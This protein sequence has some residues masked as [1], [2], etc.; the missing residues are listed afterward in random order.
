ME[1]VEIIYYLFGIAASAVAIWRFVLWL[2]REKL[3][4]DV[5]LVTRDISEKQFSRGVN[6]LRVKIM[7]EY[8]PDLILVISSG[9]ATVGG[10]LSAHLNVPAAM[11]VRSNPRLQ[12]TEPQKSKI[13][14]FP[15]DEIIKG[16]NILL[17]DDEVHSGRT[18]QTSID[19]TWKASPLDVK[20]AALLLGVGE[21]MEQIKKPDFYIYQAK[22]PGVRMFYDFIKQHT[23][24]R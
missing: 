24:T 16:R 11:V 10:I 3:P 14:V 18:L 6:W 17:V 21:Q 19:E 13:L 23:G 9:G 12:E 4:S 20:S 2:R 1:H 22:K 5:I 7:K 8:N 15:P